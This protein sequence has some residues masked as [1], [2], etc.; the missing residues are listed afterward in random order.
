MSNPSLPGAPVK[1][2]LQVVKEARVAE[3]PADL[4]RKTKF[5]NTDTTAD[6]IFL[7][8]IVHN[9]EHMGQLFAYARMTGFVRPVVEAI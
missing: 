8:I 7:R 1:R 3:T 4:Q 9:N 6:N 5:L 2:S